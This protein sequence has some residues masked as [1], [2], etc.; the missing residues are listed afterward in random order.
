MGQCCARPKEIEDREDEIYEARYEA[1]D[2]GQCFFWCCKCCAKQPRQ[3]DQDSEQEDL[4]DSYGSTRNTDE[5]H[6][7]GTTNTKD[8][9]T[10]RDPLLSKKSPVVPRNYSAAQPTA[11]PL[12]KEPNPPPPPA[13][14]DQL[15]L[16]PDEPLNDQEPHAPSCALCTAAVTTR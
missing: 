5:I 7:E 15:P 13:D 3:K 2:M 10:E 8:E 6:T 12:Y 11:P 4:S 14:N 16:Q 1:N 9:P